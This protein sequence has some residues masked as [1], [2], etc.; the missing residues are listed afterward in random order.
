[1]KHSKFLQI[2]HRSHTSSFQD[3]NISEF[4]LCIFWF[5]YLSPMAKM[6]RM[7]SLR[8]LPRMMRQHCP[9]SMFQIRSLPSPEPVI[10]RR[11]MNSR[12]NTSLQHRS[13][14]AAAEFLWSRLNLFHSWSTCSVWLMSQGGKC[15]HAITASNRQPHLESDYLTS[16]AIQDTANTQFPNLQILQTT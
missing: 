6:L 2:S 16:A 13:S 5:V 12:H 8:L 7:G 9:V 4:E 10:T 14:G 1:M 3:L 11:Y 15:T